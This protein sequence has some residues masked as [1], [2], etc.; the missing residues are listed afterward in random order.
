MK[1]ELKQ[2]I[3]SKSRNITKI[4]YDSRRYNRGL[5]L[6]LERQKTLYFIK[7]NS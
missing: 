3:K 1:R 5:E 6:A 2:E 4:G 7:M